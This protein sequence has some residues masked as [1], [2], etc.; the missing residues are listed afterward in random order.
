MRGLER[1]VNWLIQ[2]TWPVFT[3]VAHQHHIGT[4][5]LKCCVFALPW[6]PLII[7]GRLTRSTSASFMQ[8]IF[9]IG[10]LI[11]SDRRRHLKCPLLRPAFY[12]IIEQLRWNR[13][14]QTGSMTLRLV[15]STISPVP[16]VRD[17]RHL[18]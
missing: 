18:D 7:P 13:K 12:T 1:L 10:H 14:D 5:N 11:P 3:L 9:A 16:S 15:R 4:L 6:C 2:P 8:L 17:P